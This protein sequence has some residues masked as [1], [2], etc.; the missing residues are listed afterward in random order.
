MLNN[1]QLSLLLGLLAG[2]SVTTFIFFFLFKSAYE[3]RIKELKEDRQALRAELDDLTNEL[4][5]MIDN[6]FGGK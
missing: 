1:E 6:F 5:N 4:L 2:A 3:S